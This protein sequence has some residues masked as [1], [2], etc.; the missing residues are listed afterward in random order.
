[1]ST[2]ELVAGCL[3]PVPIPAVWTDIDR[4]WKIR[5]WKIRSWNP[6]ALGSSDT[7]EAVFA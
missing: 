7:V 3:C 6:F 1:M 2:R 4:S 5:S